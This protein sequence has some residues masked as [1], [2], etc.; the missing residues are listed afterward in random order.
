VQ[1]DIPIG[2]LGHGA[3]GMARAVTTCVHCGFCLAACP[4]Y[5]VLGEEMDSPRGRIVLMKQALEG[6]L[7]MQDV[8]PYVDRC[9]GCLACETACPS[10]VRYRDLLIPFR[11]RG[12]VAARTRVERWLRAGL[13][14]LLESPGAFRAA[15]TMGRWA[16]AVSSL[17]PAR[18]RPMLD[19]VP[20]SLPPVEPLARLTPAQGARRARVALLA[21]CVQ[22]VLRPSINAATVRFLA[23][24]GVEV[25]V[26]HEQGCC[27]ALAAHSGF[28]ARGTARAQANAR[29]WQDVD[30]VI[31]N[32][33]GCGSHMKDIAAAGPRVTDVSEFVDALGLRTPLSLATPTTVA[34]HDACHLSH[35]QR[36]RAAPRRLLQQIEN[37]TLVEIPDGETCCG[38]AGLYNLEHPRTAAELGRQKAAA[39]HATGARVV[40]TG[41]IGCMTQIAAHGGPDRLQVLHTI[42]LLDSAYSARG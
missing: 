18:L 17:A 20:Q 24:N 35:G 36:V 21:G 5:R 32:A 42:E 39:I 7:T 30:A 4:T 9:L 29:Y 14:S 31:T 6:S 26:P 40:V 25:V 38:S 22:R 34:Y 27:G 8:Q 15:V 1:H 33:A 37:V 28:E 16:R 11:A 10:G 3:E 23:A 12:E 41:N 13:L 2:R 19:L